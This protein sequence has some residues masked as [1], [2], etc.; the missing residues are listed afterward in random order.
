MANVSFTPTRLTLLLPFGT[1]NIS[2]TPVSWGVR[3]TTGDF[4]RA[5][6]ARKSTLFLGGFSVNVSFTPIRLGLVNFLVTLLKGDFLALP[7]CSESGEMNITVGGD[8][9]VA[10]SS[11]YPDSLSL[12]VSGAGVER[13]R[14][15][16]RM[17]VTGESTCPVD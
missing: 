6:S 9:G 12:G 17:I 7:R 10:G 4:I 11:S 16:R 8:A 13:A 14:P 2:F 15:F 3:E 5:L 1:A